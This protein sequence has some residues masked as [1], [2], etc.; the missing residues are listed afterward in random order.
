MK[1]PFKRNPK[2]ITIGGQTWQPE[3][4]SLERTLQLALLLAPYIPLLEDRRAEFG[5]Q[6]KNTAGDRPQLLSA[7]FRS[8]AH[9]MQQQMP[10]DIIKM[11]SILINKEPEWV[12]RHV[13]A[14]EI[15]SALPILDEI[16]NFLALIQ[17]IKALGLTVRYE[18]ES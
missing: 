6:L 7:L 10:G 9:E 1:N 4:M 16:N 2:T 14:T 11:I 5:R 18:R 12:A 13:K 8:L 3:P 15:L 17:S